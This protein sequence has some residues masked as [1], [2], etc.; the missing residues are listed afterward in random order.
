MTWAL[1]D[2]RLLTWAL[3]AQVTDH[4]NLRCD[5]CCTLSPHLPP[6]TTDPATLRREL[7]QAARAL[8][9]SV[10]KL[11]GGEPLLHP[12]LVACV[13]AARASGIAPV[14]SMTTNG[15]LAR[16]AP[17]ALWAA[18]DRVTVS[19][20]T[21]APLPGRTIAH[22]EERCAAHGVLLTWKPTAGF[23]RMDPATPHD[24]AE[25]RR[26]WDDCWLKVRCHMI[27]E[28]RFHPCTRPPH[29]AAAHGQ[30]LDPRDGVPLD[31]PALLEDIL[32]LL[33]RPLAACARCLG[34]SGPRI[35]HAQLPRATRRPQHAPP[36]PPTRADGVTPHQ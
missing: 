34:A 32:A 16:R 29:I 8:A 19:F 35:P 36:E 9:P 7:E 18:L 25:R 10:F 31:S 27:H 11:T 26:V 21:S 14:I 33:D 23:Q 3:E 20:Y 6:R 28:G 2:G 5:G 17:E 1:R 22:I 30:P 15:L 24:D 12:D 4:C 13:E